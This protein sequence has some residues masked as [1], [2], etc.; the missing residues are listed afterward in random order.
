M[1]LEL[2][3]G[4]GKVTPKTGEFLSRFSVFGGRDGVILQKLCIAVQLL[5]GNH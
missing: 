1:E 4:A 2:L 5:L 3:G